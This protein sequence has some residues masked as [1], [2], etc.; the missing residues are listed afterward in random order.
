M[1]QFVGA[2]VAAVGFVVGLGVLGAVV[3]TNR[4]LQVH[5]A[6]GHVVEE[7]MHGA[8]AP[9][10]RVALEIE[11]I[12]DL[13]FGEGCGLI[14]EVDQ[15][16]GACKTSVT[17]FIQT[18]G[19]FPTDADQAGCGKKPVP[20]AYDRSPPGVCP[21]AGPTISGQAGTIWPL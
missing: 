5:D 10:P 6:V 19:V 4:V 12:A 21:K 16:I 3:G 14:T 7:V 17:E 18:N 13:L 15:Q 9:E 2:C 1:D 20:T 11:P 8:V